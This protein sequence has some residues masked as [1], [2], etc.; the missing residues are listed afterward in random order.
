MAVLMAR[1]LPT[2]WQPPSTG[3]TDTQ[4]FDD[5]EAFNPAACR[6]KISAEEQKG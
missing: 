5:Y 1:S 3:A 4:N 6:I 2:H